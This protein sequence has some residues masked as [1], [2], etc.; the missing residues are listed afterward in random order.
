M[1]SISPIQIQILLFVSN[2]NVDLS[3]VSYLAKELNVSKPTVSNVVRVLLKKELIEKDSSPS[4]NRRYNLILSKKGKN[5][6]AELQDYTLP[7]AAV[8]NN[9]NE[10]ERNNFYKII[11]QL[12][13]NGII[14]VQRNCF[15]C[16]YYSGNKQD[17]HHCNLMNINLIS[18]D[19]TIP[20]KLDS[21]L[22][23]KKH[24]NLLS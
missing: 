15:G 6:A 21:R 14:Q 19:W 4:D 18:P 12:N 1:H 9:I 22:S 13:Q 23:Y 2:H 20:K 17:S 3:N 7:V 24:L 8:M 16:K 11:S 10:E 5:L